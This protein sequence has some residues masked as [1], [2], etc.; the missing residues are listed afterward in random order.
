[1]TATGRIG[2]DSERSKSTRSRLRVLANDRLILAVQRTCGS[3]TTGRL[4]TACS[5][6]SLTVS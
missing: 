6:I 2:S 5:R 1:M 4:T 3:S